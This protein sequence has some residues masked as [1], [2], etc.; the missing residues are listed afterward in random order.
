MTGKRRTHHR[1]RRRRKSLR[2]CY[3]ML[4]HWEFIRMHEQSLDFFI[5]MAALHA[6]ISQQDQA[7]SLHG[8]VLPNLST[9]AAAIIFEKLLIPT[10]LVLAESIESVQI[11]RDQQTQPTKDERLQVHKVRD[12]RRWRRRQNLHADFLHHK[13][14]LFGNSRDLQVMMEGRGPEQLHDTIGKGDAAAV[15]KLQSAIKFNGGGGGQSPHSN[16]GRA[17]D[18]SLGYFDA[19][20]QKINTGGAALQGS[21]WVWLA[22]DKELKKLV[23]ET[24]ANQ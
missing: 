10:S 24:T 19:L 11:F 9:A 1:H 5:N 21:G 16:L 13:L 8:L 15:V 4:G 14:S 6:L 20:V 12:G 7:L 3:H 23:V 2:H 18:T 17:I 22:L